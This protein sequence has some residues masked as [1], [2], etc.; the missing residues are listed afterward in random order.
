MMTEPEQKMS[1][2]AR[3]VFELFIRNGWTLALAE[4]CTGGMI[5]EKIT[6]I[7]GS[8]EMFGY[9]LVSYSDEVKEEYLGVDRE[10]VGKLTTV[11]AEVAVQMAEGARK[12]GRADYAAAVTGIAGPGVGGYIGKEVGLV[13]ISVSG[14]KGTIVRECHFGSSLSRKEIREKTCITA[15]EMVWEFSQGMTVDDAVRT[16]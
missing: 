9:G 1:S 12:N 6:D 7:P 14:E 3:K 16:R 15:L 13:Y 10:T 2:A 4:S 5:A 11:S 8:S